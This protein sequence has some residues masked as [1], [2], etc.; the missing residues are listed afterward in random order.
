MM[1]SATRM[2]PLAASSEHTLEPPTHVL[3]GISPFVPTYPE[4]EGQ[5]QAN[6]Y[7]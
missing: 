7:H 6:H 2:A 1:S 3:Q 4:D 5:R